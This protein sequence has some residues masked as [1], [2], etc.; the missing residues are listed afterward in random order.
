MGLDGAITGVMFESANISGTYVWSN[1]STLN[2][3]TVPSAGLHSMYMWAREERITITRML[4]TTNS[5][6]TPSGSVAD[7]TWSTGGGTVTDNPDNPSLPQGPPPVVDD[8]T[9]D[10]FPFSE[11]GAAPLSTATT[12]N[13]ETI[14]GIN[15][16]TA[17]SISGAGGTYS[18]DGGSFTSATGVI[19][20]GQTV[21]VRVTSSSSNSTE[22]ITTLTIGTV[23]QSFSVTTEASGSVGLTLRTTT[24][25]VTSSGT[26]VQDLDIRIP[27]GGGVGIQISNGVTNTT[28]TNC[29]ISSVD[30]HAI[31]G[32]SIGSI[33]VHDCEISECWGDGVYVY[34]LTS[35]NIYDN[36]INNVHTGVNL[37][38]GKEGNITVQNNWI[39]NVFR[40]ET[41]VASANANGVHLAYCA[42]PDMLV[43]G[44]IIINEQG[45]SRPEDDINFYNS[46]GTAVSPITITNNKMKGQNEST[47]STTIILGDGTGKY[48]LAEDNI[49][50]NAG[51]VGMGMG[52]NGYHVARRNKIYS[53]PVYKLTDPSVGVS[54]VGFSSGYTNFVNNLPP[55]D[56]L[57]FEDNDVTF[58][59]AAN[60]NN[61][62]SAEVLSPWYIAPGQSTPAG[63]STNRFDTSTSQPASLTDAIWLS[64]W[65][66]RPVRIT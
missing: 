39:K 45:A 49:M 3:V 65:D 32:T 25:P 7:S 53:A 14:I 9:P 60:Y 15:V 56:G 43:D 24:F 38:Q 12:S 59:K 64:A 10:P 26:T 57:V 6:Y 66:I 5:G 55:I 48:S 8:R 33:T 36:T 58:W 16:P 29:R 42:G 54:N 11:V 62:G 50:V 13:L 44:N 17:I 40:R 41:G 20:A 37:W 23:S 61:T 1:N 4:L 63:W 34:G 35:A 2:T 22:V 52:G 19:T 51:Q 31:T 21:Q 18:I 28:I 46:S 47:S 27:A 30:S